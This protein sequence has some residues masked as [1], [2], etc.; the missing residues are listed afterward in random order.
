MNF[1]AQAVSGVKWTTLSTLI[2]TL[3]QFIQLFIIARLLDP[4]DFGLMAIIMV[5]IGFAQAFQDMGISSAIIQRQ[6]LSHSQLSSLYWLNLASGVV[7]CLIVITISPLVA[8][9]YNDPRITNLMAILSS[10]FIL[11][12]V[13]NQ[14]RILCQKE[15]DFSTLEIIN[16]SSSFAGLVVAVVSA[17]QGLGILAL[18]YAMLTQAGLASLLF[19]WIGLY[20]Y[21]KPSLVY[22]HSELKG[23]YSFGFYQVG[24]RCINYI[25]TNAD[26]MLIGKLVGMNATGFYNLAWNL[27]IFPVSKVNPIINKVAFPIYSKIQNNTA[28]LSRYYTFNVKAL[29]IITIPILAFLFFFSHEIVQIVYGEGWDTTATLLPILALVGIL[30]A[31]G[32]PGG[33]L[34]LALGWANVGF[35]WNLLW[36]LC[37]V[38]ALTT[39]LIISPTPQ[40]AAY[41]LLGLSLTLGTCWHIL[42]AKIS[43]FNYWPIARYFLKIFAVVMTIGWL[44][45]LIVKAVDLNSPLLRVLIGGFVCGTVYIAYLLL[46]EKSILNSLR[47]ET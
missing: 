1:K 28:A 19:L 3:L 33:A 31:L 2:I 11:V 36:A 34:I 20:R 43:K 12:A 16:V 15:M 21:H 22:Q 14:Y 9:F 46:F 40:T 10:V 24:E 5:V 23:F 6:E 25:A 13:G 44:G 45:S 17:V 26:K 18:V 30:R 37:I 32:N 4:E 39:A 27:I 8:N 42:V 47:R 38:A 29:S 41:T 35:W 7:L